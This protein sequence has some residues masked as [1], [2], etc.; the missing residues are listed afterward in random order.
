MNHVLAFPF[1]ALAAAGAGAQSFLYTDFSSTAGLTLLGNAVRTGNVLRLTDN[2][3]N[4]AGWAWRQTPLHAVAGFDTIFTFRITPAG[5]A[6]Q[7]EG[8]VFVLHGHPY[9]AAAQ[10]GTGFGLGYGV[11]PFNQVGIGWSIAIEY[12]TF[13]DSQLGDTSANELSIHTRGAL[14]NN[15]HEGYSIARTTPAVNLADGQVHSM[16]VRYV[17]G[18]IEVFLDGAATPALSRAYDLVAGGLYASGNP[19]PGVAL[20]DGTG[21]AGFCATTRTGALS[22]VCDILSWA[23]AS[24]PLR[25]PC[26][27]GSMGQDVLTVQASSGGVARRIQLATWQSFGIGIG[28]PPAFGPGAPYVLFLS[29]LPQ[30][31]AFGTQLGFGETCFPVL[32][33]GPLDLVLADTFGVFPALLPALPAPHTI[34]IPPAVVTTPLAFTLQAVMLASSSPLAF[35]VTNAIDVSFAPAP[36]PVISAVSPASAQPGQ[37]IGILGSGFLP[38]L[39]LTV[40]G[41]AVPFQYF[42]PLGIDFAYPAGLPCNSTL[43]VT[44]P[45]NQSV[46]AA[47]NP[48]PVITGTAWSSGPAAGGQ[49]FQ[50][51]GSGFAYGTTVT[52]GGT[53][54][55]VMIAGPTALLMYTPPG[56]VGIAPVVV[57]TPGGC[58]ATTTY[59]YY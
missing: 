50:I 38:G 8:M 10:A 35:G 15:E 49:P 14:P 33:A 58:T 39:Q 41:S 9:G 51:Q 42:G 57:T 3:A 4:Q 43:R 44:N 6:S 26:Y 22:E 21:Y 48:T 27:D 45:D 5:G 31:G 40:N 28:A 1:C 23:W 13:V 32:P 19:A 47:V 54:A 55:V 2:V 36:P 46:T 29:L 16:Q 20:P 53:A 18:L 34:A 11:G 25:H 24:P 12:D 7:G 52:I 59:T 37:P 56:A 30:P 17:P